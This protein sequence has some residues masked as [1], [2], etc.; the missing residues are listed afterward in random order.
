MVANSSIKLQGRACVSAGMEG[1]V[2][3]TAKA[4]KILQNQSYFP[5]LSCIFTHPGW[6]VCTSLFI[7]L[8]TQKKYLAIKTA[9][10]VEQCHL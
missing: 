5:A 10:I 7:N 4:I 6:Q 3:D 8:L 2:V 1:G 9:K